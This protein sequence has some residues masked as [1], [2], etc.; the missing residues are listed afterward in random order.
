MITL[1]ERGAES[2][3]MKESNSTGVLPRY[4]WNS[5]KKLGSNWVVTLE[6]T[7][8]LVMRGDGCPNMKNQLV[9][10]Y[11]LVIIRIIT[12]NQLVTG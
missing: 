12:R 3:S 11:Y 10:E 2:S 8:T 6:A 1:V 4:Y 9:L 5:N 7:I